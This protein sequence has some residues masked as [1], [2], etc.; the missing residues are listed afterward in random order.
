[1]TKRK[2]VKPLNIE[3]ITFTRDETPENN[4]PEKIEQ[5]LRNLVEIAI[6]IMGK[7]KKLQNGLKV[8]QS[9]EVWKRQDL[10]EKL[11]DDQASITDTVKG[12]EMSETPEKEIRIRLS[13]D[14]W[15]QIGEEAR[16]LRMSP[17]AIA[18]KWVLEGLN[19]Q[20]GEVEIDSL[21]RPSKRYRVYPI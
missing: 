13:Q 9:P 20:I 10:E 5:R 11:K 21:S 17:T 12:I 4:T 16:R 1:M 18:S 6:D 2:K 8:E 3:N 7:Q 15:E 19:R 14:S